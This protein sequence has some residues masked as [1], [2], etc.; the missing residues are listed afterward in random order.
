MPP[1]ERWKESPPPADEREARAAALVRSIRPLGPP[2]DR[3]IDAR[4][5]RLQRDLGREASGLFGWLTRWRLWIAGLSTLLGLNLAFGAVVWYGRWRADKQVPA[6]QPTV[7]SAPAAPP[8]A[9]PSPLLAPPP[10][11]L[12]RAAVAAPTPQKERPRAERPEPPKAAETDA[13]AEESARV[14]RALQLLAAGDA[15]SA[16]AAAQDY[17]DRYPAGSLRGEAEMA[18]L[19]ALIA[20]SRHSEALSLLDGFAEASFAGLPRPDELRVL[21]GELL[22]EKGRFADALASFSAAGTEALPDLHERALWGRAVCRVR[23]GDLAGSRREFAQYLS[24][25]PEGRHARE[26]RAALGSAEPAH[27]FKK[28]M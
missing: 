8:R 4:L 25:F 26:A 21:R 27:D 3:E 11:P 24:A 13:L 22:L 14:G 9:A 19:D 12:P 16:L 20:L 6:A 18:R 15:A 10:R 2:G 17:L 7:Q 1:L 23:L 5:Q 28:P